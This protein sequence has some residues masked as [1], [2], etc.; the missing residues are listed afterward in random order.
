[1]NALEKKRIISA[2]KYTWPFY[3]VV[4]LAIPLLMNVV[5]GVT[6][7]VPGYKRLTIFVSGEVIN[8]KKLRDD[9]LETYKEKELK[10]FSCVS[11]K[12]TDGTYD[13][14]LSVAGYNSAD[15]LVIPISKLE[16][17]EVSAFA[18]DLSDELIN[19]YYAGYTLFQ[20]KDVNYGIKIDKE[21]VQEY[22]TLPSED[23]YLILNGKSV[24]L[25]DYSKKPISE[26][27][28]ALQVVK[29][30]GM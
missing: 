10:T 4:A 8:S 24:N 6:H 27:D 23:C 7:K 2:L 18:L 29:N 21:K 16:S 1:M 15:I 11:A 17:V 22:M 19:S 9:M 3:L 30:W 28:M 5:F 25:G 14:K 13:T 12:P 26:H 20:Q